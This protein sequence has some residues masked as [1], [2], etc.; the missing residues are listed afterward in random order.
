VPGQRLSLRE[1]LPEA[2]P[3]PSATDFAKSA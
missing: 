3:E 2:A 1:G